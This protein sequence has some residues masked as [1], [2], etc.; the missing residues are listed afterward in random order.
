MLIHVSIIFVLQSDRNLMY[1]T[2]ALFSS[3]ASGKNEKTGYVDQETAKGNSRDKERCDE[4]TVFS[5]ICLIFFISELYV[6]NQ[7]LRKG[8]FHDDPYEM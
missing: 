2:A 5:R 3:F 6:I 4:K 8:V 7:F 1:N